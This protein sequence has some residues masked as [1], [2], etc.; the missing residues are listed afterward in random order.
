MIGVR[1][2]GAVASSVPICRPG[3]EKDAVSNAK[4]CNNQ[5]TI[6][7]GNVCITQN[8][9]LGLSNRGWKYLGLFDNI[10]LSS[11]ITS[12]EQLNLIKVPNMYNQRHSCRMKP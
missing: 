9:S 12:H 6:K 5:G 1:I 4:R 2:P 7:I 3:S 10:P 11:T 8:E